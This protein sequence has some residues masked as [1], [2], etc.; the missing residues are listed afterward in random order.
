MERVGER[1][2]RHRPRVHA[3]G[4]QGIRHAFNLPDEA[5]V[6]VGAGAPISFTGSRTDYGVFLYLSFE[7]KFLR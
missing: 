7:H 2:R 4:A 5:Q 1:D 6:V 3:H